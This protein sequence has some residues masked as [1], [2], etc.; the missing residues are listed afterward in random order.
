MA[1]LA[2]AVSVAEVLAED[3][4]AVAELP[5]AGN[6]GMNFVQSRL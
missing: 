1:V 4:A 2:V 6:S 5:A 3:Q